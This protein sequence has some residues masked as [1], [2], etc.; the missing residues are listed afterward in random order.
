MK[1]STSTLI[2]F[3]DLPKDSRTLCM[4]VLLPRPIHTRDGYRAAL[5]VAE[6]MAGH[7]LTKDQDDYLEALTTFVGEWETA[8]E[9]NLPKATPLE[10]LAFL[11]AENGLSGSDLAQILGTSRSLAS[12]LLSG[13][14]Q[15][16]TAHIRALCARFQLNPAAFLQN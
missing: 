3:A 7:D 14:R 6:A 10:L 5:A 2:A 8:H 4:D 11:L 13:E 1:S 12:R 15:L 16:T 9:E